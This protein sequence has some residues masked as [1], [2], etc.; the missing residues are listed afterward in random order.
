MPVVQVSHAPS[1]EMYDTV[2]KQVELEGDRPQGLILHAASEMED[3]TVQIVSVYE[4]AEAA[5]A[6]ERERLMPAF[7]AAG[8]MENVQQA[9]P[10]PK[11]YE[12]FHYVS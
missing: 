10:P 12:T 2:Q 6:F 8:V 5:Q 4:S 7:Q 9:G 3:G 11:R 1:R